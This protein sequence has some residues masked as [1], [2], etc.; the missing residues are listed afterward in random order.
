MLYVFLIELVT[1]FFLYLFI[2][3]KRFG[4]RIN[5][6]LTAAALSTLFNIYLYFRKE[7]FLLEGMLLL[8]IC[9]RA[10]FSSTHILACESYASNY[11]TLG[12]GYAVG[13][14]RLS[15]VIGPYILFPL[16]FI[17]PYL[18][19]LFLSIIMFILFVT[20]L[21]IRED[22]TQKPLE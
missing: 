8:K 20:V 13:V 2:D 21:L 3:N 11:R 15:G 5:L 14:G 10:L 19:F 1:S 6:I 9:I 7:K 4:G 17:E 16:Y 18:P 12:V 22:K